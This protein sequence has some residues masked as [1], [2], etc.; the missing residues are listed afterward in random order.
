MVQDASP[1]K[2]PMVDSRSSTPTLSAADRKERAEHQQKLIERLTKSPKRAPDDAKPEWAKD[3]VKL[4]PEK[5]DKMVERLYLQSVKNLAT[6]REQQE[7]KVYQYENPKTLPKTAIEENVSRMMDHEISKR[8]T[9]Q[10]RLQLK[11]YQEAPVKKLTTEEVHENI[12]RLYDASTRNHN[13]R[14]KQL[15]AKY[16]FKPA[17]EPKKLTKTEMQSYTERLAKPKPP[18]SLENPLYGATHG[19]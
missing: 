7:K 5:Q 17:G 19:S 10:E 3:A 12:K 4:K 6:R 13:E 9:I 14:Q 1:L 8:K 11:Y 18:S 16:A 2:L 15:E